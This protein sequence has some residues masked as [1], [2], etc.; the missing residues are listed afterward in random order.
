M[1]PDSSLVGSPSVTLKIAT[2]AA[3][4]GASWETK[5]AIQLTPLQAEQFGEVHSSS[6]AIKTI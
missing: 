1:Q 4:P 3:A 6:L 2:K 5:A